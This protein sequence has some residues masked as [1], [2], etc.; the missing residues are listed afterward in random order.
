M[1]LSL[2]TGAKK[3]NKKPVS[4]SG[5]KGAAL[6]PPDVK[7]STL[8]LVTERINLHSF[9]QMW[10]PKNFF[11]RNHFM[12]RGYNS[13]WIRRCSTMQPPCYPSGKTQHTTKV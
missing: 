3:K 1:F 11:N 5:E 10:R 9:C 8:V 4:Q 6:S 7:Q 2:V 12:M 13:V